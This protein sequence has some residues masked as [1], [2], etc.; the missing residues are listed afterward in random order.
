[1]S[2]AGPASS[3]ALD[4]TAAFLID[5]DV[6]IEHLR[7]RAWAAGLLA[8]I[9]ISGGVVY[10]SPVTTAEIY[11][12]I[13]S[14]EEVATERLFTNLPCLQI[15]DAV[16]RQAGEYLRRFRAS[17]GLALGDAL[18]GATARAHDLV[19]LTLNRRHYPMPD[20][21]LATLPDDRQR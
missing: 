8:S 3:P 5:S 21:R 12:G 14:G 13:R 17:H 7:G 18:I 2:V 1:M 10:Y 15:D 19:L 6:V 4:P 11:Q 20:V 16:G 9:A